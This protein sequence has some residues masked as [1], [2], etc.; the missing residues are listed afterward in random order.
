MIC[1]GDVNG[2]DDKIV[3][4]GGTLFYWRRRESKTYGSF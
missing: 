2:F 1:I 3:R 4:E